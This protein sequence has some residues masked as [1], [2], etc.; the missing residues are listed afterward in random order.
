MANALL[1]LEETEH[2]P[3]NHPF[4]AGRLR[5]EKGTEMLRIIGLALVVVS[6]IVFA[7]GADAVP[8]AR[9]WIV[10]DYS[11]KTTA[12]LAGGIAT[13]IAGA[14]LAFIGGYRTKSSLPVNE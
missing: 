4:K 12:F 14:T 7:Q 11:F 8:T 1:H 10:D 2:M 6:M 13:M 3:I 9:Q 5:Q